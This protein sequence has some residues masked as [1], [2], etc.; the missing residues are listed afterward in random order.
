[1]GARQDISN[2]R[3]RLE[4]EHAST[5]TTTRDHRRPL[6]RY[7]HAFETGTLPAD[8]CAPRVTELSARRDELTAHRDQLAHQLHAAMPEL[9]RRELIDEMR[10][11]IEG[12]VNHGSQHVV[13]Q[14]FAN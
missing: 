8:L 13:Q 7:L 5:G 9:A 1:M 14:L 4:A 3:P 12:V 6:D 11:Q 10:I 2:E